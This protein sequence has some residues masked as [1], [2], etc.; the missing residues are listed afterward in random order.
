M[1]SVEHLFAFAKCE[2]RHSQ[3]ACPAVG[4]A[5]TSRRMRHGLAG[6]GRRIAPRAA[7]AAGRAARLRLRARARAAG[8]RRRRTWRSRSRTTRCSS[9]TATTGAR[10]ALQQARAARRHADPGEPVVDDRHA[11]AARRSADARRPRTSEY[12]FVA[13]DG[14][15][16][17]DA[18]DR[19][20]RP[21]RAGRSGAG[22]GDRQQEDRRRTRSR[23]TTSASSPARPREHFGA[24]RPLLDLERAELRGLA[25]SAQQAPRIYRS[26]YVDGLQ[27]DQGGQPQA[28]GPDRRDVAVRDPQGP[29][30]NARRSRSCAR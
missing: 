20:P 28:A 13:Y 25:R 2:N 6:H 15:V 11:G 7:A 4:R 8:P 14:L 29:A 5:Y 3:V 22:V 24:G 23:P 19:H 1:G 18:R 9:P 27:R 26:M 12:N 30:R 16:A 10:R 21:V 17:R